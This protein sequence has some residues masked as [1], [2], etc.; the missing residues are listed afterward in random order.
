MKTKCNIVHNKANLTK[1]VL[2]QKRW[3]DGMIGWT[4][5]RNGKGTWE[6]DEKE[7]NVQEF[8][9]SFPLKF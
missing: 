8:I 2:A 7:L 9:K 4:N 6:N 1:L 5:K 3:R